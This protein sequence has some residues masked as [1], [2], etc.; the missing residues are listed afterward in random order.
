MS[1]DEETGAPA[2]DLVETLARPSDDEV[3]WWTPGG[4]RTTT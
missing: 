2:T 3:T 1:I 4:G